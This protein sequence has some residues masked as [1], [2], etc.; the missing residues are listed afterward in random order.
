MVLADVGHLPAVLHQ[1][2]PHAAARDRQRAA[3]SRGRGCAGGRDDVFQRERPGVREPVRRWTRGLARAVRRAV[4]AVGGAFP[5][6][7]DSD[8]RVLRRPRPAARIADVHVHDVPA[9]I[10]D[11]R[12]GRGEGEQD[13]GADVHHGSADVDARHRARGDVRR[14]V[15]PHVVDRRRDAAPEGVSDYGCRR[16]D[17][18]SPLLHGVGR[19]PRVPH[20]DLLQPRE[21][22]VHRRPVR[23]LRHGHAPLRVLSDVREPGAGSQEGGE[24]L[25]PHGFHLCR[26]STREQGGRGARRDVGDAVRRPA[27]AGRAHEHH[28]WR[29]GAVRG[30]GVVPR[31]GVAHRARDAAAVVVCLFGQVL[32]RTRRG[33]GT[34][35]RRG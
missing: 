19:S 21:A 11:Q 8:Q 30:D 15:H 28:G 4:R 22:G 20:R 33:R 24:R 3:S 7:R 5:A 35:I 6:A 18:L 9:R 23:A 12:V 31:E 27:V 34:G 29:R 25:V 16:V 26:R 17:C 32:G 10:A 13:A 14:V 1:R 2:I